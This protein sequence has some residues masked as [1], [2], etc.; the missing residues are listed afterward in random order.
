VVGAAPDAPCAEGGLGERIS[1]VCGSVRGGDVADVG[2]QLRRS[3][4]QFPFRAKR[5]RGGDERSYRRQIWALAATALVGAAGGGR[6]A[7]LC[8]DQPPDPERGGDPAAVGGAAGRVPVELRAGV[9]VCGALPALA[10]GAGAGGAAGQPGLSAVEDGR[11]CADPDVG[12]VLC[13]GALCSVLVSAC[14][15]V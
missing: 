1:A 2:C 9:R 6:G 5:G 3:R 8:G 14:R 7:A 13:R 15:V 4:F 11:G 12:R 10:G